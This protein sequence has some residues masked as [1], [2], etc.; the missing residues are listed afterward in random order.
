MA[1][2]AL[3]AAWLLWYLLRHLCWPLLHPHQVVLLQL[4]LLLLLLVLPQDARQL[5]EQC[6]RCPPVVLRLPN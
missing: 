3:P 5:W 4:L 1:S 2:C 6:C